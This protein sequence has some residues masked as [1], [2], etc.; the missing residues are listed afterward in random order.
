MSPQQSLHILSMP[1]RARRNRI[2]ECSVCCSQ[3]DSAKQCLD[4]ESYCGRWFASPDS[5]STNWINRHRPKQI[6]LI[7]GSSGTGFRF[8]GFVPPN[9]SSVQNW[10]P[11]I[12]CDPVCKVPPDK[13]PG[14]RLLVHRSTDPPDIN[15]TT[16]NNLNR[17]NRS[18]VPKSRERSDRQGGR[19]GDKHRRYI[20]CQ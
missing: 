1:G 9:R 19:W 14:Y 4:I 5:Q 15:S 16:L 10:P 8:V 2:Y 11:G 7:A 13:P 17:R 3:H 12:D 6:G 20:T 18:L